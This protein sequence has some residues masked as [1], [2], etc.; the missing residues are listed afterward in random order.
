VLTTDSLTKAQ[1]LNPQQLRV[2]AVKLDWDLIWSLG[3]GVRSQESG[4]R[5]QESGVRSQE[6]GVRSQESGVRSQESGVRSQ[7]EEEEEL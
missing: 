7:E 4:V 5:S 2:N 3:I 6:S 1:H